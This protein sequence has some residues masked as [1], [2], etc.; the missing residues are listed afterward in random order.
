MFKSIIRLKVD[1]QAA[2]AG[3]SLG[4]ALGQAGVPTGDFCKRFNEVSKIYEKGIPINTIIRVKTDRTYEIEMKGPSISYLLK[5]AVGIDKG[6]SYSGHLV[7]T[8][9]CITNYMLYELF[10]LSNAVVKRTNGYYKTIKG[11]AQSCGF[12]ILNYECDEII[13]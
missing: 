6:L 2:A 3:Q 5:S 8:N 1:A 9:I 10:I 7:D 11:T 4:P 12:Y 13:I